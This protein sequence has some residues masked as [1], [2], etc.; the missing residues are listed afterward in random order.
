M[1]E[2]IS[3]PLSWK[4]HGDLSAANLKAAFTADGH[5]LISIKTYLKDGKRLYAAIAVKNEGLDWNWTEKM[6]PDQLRNKMNDESMRL[7]SLDC[8]QDGE[9]MPTCAPRATHSSP[10]IMS[11]RERKSANAGTLEDRRCLTCTSA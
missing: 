7:I 5:R 2:I 1:S 3:P 10:A 8:F 4:L 11:C 9:D 6:K